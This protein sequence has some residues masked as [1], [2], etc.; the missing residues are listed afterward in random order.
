[1]YSQA[2]YELVSLRCSAGDRDYSVAVY[3]DVSPFEKRE[4]ENALPEPIATLSN[5]SVYLI[6]DGNYFVPVSS[7]FYFYSFNGISNPLAV[8]NDSLNLRN[9]HP[10]E[11]ELSM[12][13][14]IPDRIGHLDSTLRYARAE[15][16]T[17]RSV[18]KE[19]Y[20]GPTPLSSTIAYII[21]REPKDSD[22][23][24][25]C[26]NENSTYA[27]VTT[28]SGILYTCNYDN[29]CGP[30]YLVMENSFAYTPVEMVCESVEDVFTTAVLER[31]MDS[32]GR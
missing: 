21:L 13:A 26:T 2:A 30:K 1:L 7:E 24:L 27:N 8:I 16:G 3:L 28:P 9:H 17:S 18:I 4:I 11:E 19:W 22:L 10:L 20:V 32:S 6:S 15:F 12:L 23:I 31:V 14:R 5:K 25:G 29:M